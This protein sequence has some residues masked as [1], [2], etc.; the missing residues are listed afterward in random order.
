LIFADGPIDPEQLTN[1]YNSKATTA[2]IAA[3]FTKG[4]L[5]DHDHGSGSEPG[6]GPGPKPGPGPAKGPDPLKTLAESV[7]NTL[8]ILGDPGICNREDAIFLG[9]SLPEVYYRSP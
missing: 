3:L 9:E 8:I 2:R 1:P 5:N 7:R 4:P 6:P